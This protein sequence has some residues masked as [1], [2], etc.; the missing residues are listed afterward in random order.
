MIFENIKN[1]DVDNLESWQN[2]IFITF[3]I[4]W[5][6]DEV[7]SYTLDIVEKYNIKATFFVTHKTSLL[8]RMRV[9][10]NIELGIHPNFNPLLNGDF[11]YGKNI[12]EVI[13][14]Y[15]NIVPEAVSVRSHSMTQNSPI[16]DSF[17]KFGLL[18][19]CNTFIPF[20]SG[21]E[22]QPYEHWTEELIKV[23]YFWEDDI[24]CI[25]NW[26]WDVKK[27]M[28]YS[29]IK[30]FDFHPIHIFLNTEHLDRYEKS[31]EWHNCVE[32]LEK[33]IY[34]GFG[35]HYFLINLIK[36]GLEK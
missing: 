31:R 36:K 12:N 28:N 27:I 23:P 3:D 5:C 30:V 7:L 26:E 32:N 15:K 16:L 18:Y 25:Y 4:D 17:E 6:S 2:K 34:N 22:L 24:H 11:R 10:P 19:D 14:Y 33:Q 1:I 20:S 29:G 35:T 21:I 9:N 13:K 8:E